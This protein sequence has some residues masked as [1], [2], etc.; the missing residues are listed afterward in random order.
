V[1]Q[2]SEERVVR[3]GSRIARATAGMVAALALATGIAACGGDDSSSSSSGSSG[4]AAEKQDMSITV[5]LPVDDSSYAP[6]YLAVDKGL[7]KAEGLDVK[8]VAFQSGSDLGKAVIGGSVEIANSAMSEMVAGIQQRQPLKAFWGGM[9]MLSFSWW[10]R[11]PIKSVEQA[12]G[13]KW[14]VTRVGSSTDFLTRYLL[15][16]DGLD[17]EKDAKIVGVGP[18]AGAQAAIK[19]NQIQVATASQPSDFFYED[20]GYAKIGSQ[21]DFSDSYP[22]HVSYSREEFLQKNP[23]AVE[24]YLRAV[25]KGTQLAKSDPEAAMATMAKYPKVPEKYLQ[26]TYDANLPG[27]DEDGSVSDKAGMDV[28]WQIGIQNKQFAKELPESEWLD[29]KWM[30]SSDWKTSGT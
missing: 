23:K 12:K 21:A 9:N 22:T 15:T 17:A 19:A 20:E 30:D 4:G 8:L 29:R 1:R 18:A 28:F 26:R 13:K 14:G 16:K 7:F 5:G 2:N 25:I 3:R 27:W 6:L 10:A 11:P 24:A